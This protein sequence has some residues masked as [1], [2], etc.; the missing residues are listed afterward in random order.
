VTTD[1]VLAYTNTQGAGAG[2]VCTEDSDVSV[3]GLGELDFGIGYRL[4]NRWTVTGGYRLLT[5]CGVVTAI[6]QMPTEYV[7]R[8]S[9]GAIRADD[10]LFLHGAYV[11]MNCNW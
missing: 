11:G 4:N 6:G 2:D 8:A 10:C 9:A 1:T 7:T 3:A 5:A